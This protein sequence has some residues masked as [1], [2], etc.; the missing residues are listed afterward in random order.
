[1]IRVE[2]LRTAGQHCTI[3]APSHSCY[4]RRQEPLSPP[5]DLAPASRASPNDKAEL[6]G[7][8]STALG[9]CETPQL[10]MRPAAP[11]GSKTAATHSLTFASRP[12]PVSTLEPSYRDQRTSSSSSSGRATH[13]GDTGYALLT[14]VQLSDI[15]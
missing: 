14:Y 8:A 13:S 3:V 6:R 4:A 15:P 5:I 1:M 7:A 11:P 9:R 10:V 12:S 2:V